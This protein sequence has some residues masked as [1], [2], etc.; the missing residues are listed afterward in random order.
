MGVNRAELRSELGRLVGTHWETGEMDDAINAAIDAAWP[1]IRQAKED[2]SL[3]ITSGIYTYT[4]TATDIGD[5][6]VYE[7]RIER[8]NLPH[9]LCRR[10]TQKCVDGQWQI[11][12]AYDLISTYEGK[13]VHCYYHAP[14]ARLTDDATETGLPRRYLV[15]FSA[16]DLATGMHTKRGHYNVEGYQEMIPVWFE[17]AERIKRQNRTLGLTRFQGYMRE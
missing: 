4:P 7:V 13:T 15:Y 10:W 9:L 16:A 12:F 6:G 17:L 3:T 1:V 8:T 2:T 11:S 5:K 14:Y